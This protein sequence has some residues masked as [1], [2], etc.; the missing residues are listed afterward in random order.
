MTVFTIELPI[1]STD[2]DSDG[3]VNNAVFFQLQEDGRVQMLLDLGFIGPRHAAEGSHA[4]FFTI[5]ETGCRYLLR[6]RWPGRLLIETRVTDVRTK[7]FRSEYEIRQAT[8]GELIAE[9]Y[10]AQ[11]WLG[12]AGS[13]APIPDA[14]REALNAVLEP[15]AAA[16]R[17]PT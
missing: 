17:W 13:P 16:R 1:R 15:S 7:S 11:V 2:I 6:A 10:S 9:G 3:I 5:A 12:V 14:A 8:S 4:R